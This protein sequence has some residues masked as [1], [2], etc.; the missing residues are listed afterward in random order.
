MLNCA[1]TGQDGYMSHV[2]VSGH[3]ALDFVGTLKW[4]RSAPE[5]LLP[6]PLSPQAWLSESGFLTAPGLPTARELDDARRARE[7]IYALVSRRAAGEPLPAADVRRLSELARQ[8]TVVPQL[9]ASGVR[10]DGGTRDGVAAM[11]RAAVELLADDAAVLR[12]CSRPECTRVFL[13]RSR[14][15]RRTWC[16]MEEC[17]NRAKVAA[18]RR[19]R[20]EERLER[21][22]D[23]SAG[24]PQR[25]R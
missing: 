5:E 2:F 16:G 17:G 10:H 1:D 18:Y 4:R 22:R 19:R 24:Q 3:A 23:P 20:A 8:A 25:A 9:T 7:V 15:H 21:P 14:G 12:E 13:D 6:T 11:A